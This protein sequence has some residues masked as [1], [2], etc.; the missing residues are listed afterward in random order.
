MSKQ[1][2]KQVSPHTSV[3]VDEEDETRVLSTA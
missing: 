2:L 3:W 1:V